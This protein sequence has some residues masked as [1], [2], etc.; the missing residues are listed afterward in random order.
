[1]SLL[2]LFRQH[3]SDYLYRRHHTAGWSAYFNLSRISNLGLDLYD[4]VD[5]TN[6]H[7]CRVF[8]Q[9]IGATNLVIMPSISGLFFVRLSAVYSR[10]KYVIAF[11]GSLWLVI[12]GIFIYD[13]TTMLSR[14]SDRGQSIRCFMVRHTDAWGYIGTAVYDTLMYIAMSWQLASFGVSD[15]WT[16]RARSFIT[17]GGLSGLSKV[18]LRS[19]QAYYL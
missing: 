7:T 13:T 5:S 3:L 11:F 19:G 15:H 10:D 4:D 1:M 6:A 14:V 16:S 9:F 17:G 8:V 18:L 2:K 12:L